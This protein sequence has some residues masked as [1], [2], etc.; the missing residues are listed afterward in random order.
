MGRHQDWIII[1]RLGNTI[2]QNVEGCIIE[3]GIGR[4]TPIFIKFADE[5]KR[6]LYCFD[7][8]EK[9]CI[10]AREHGCK[11]FFGNSPET[12][13]EFPD[14]PVAMGLIDGNHRYEVV[15]QETNFF[16]K[17]L[18]VGGIL[19]LHDTYPPEK[20]VQKNGDGQIGCGDVYLVRQELETC[21][22]IQFFTWPYTAVNC[23][24]T[25]IMNKEPNRPYFRK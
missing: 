13:K 12:L 18:S 8:L 20:W 14:V 3:I 17:K 10:W 6:E 16:L 2:L 11:A 7:M 25:M 19:F 21:A 24:L 5:F 9:K 1:E 23:G 15:I 4:S 22:D